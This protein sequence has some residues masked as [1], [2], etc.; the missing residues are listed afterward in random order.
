MREKSWGLADHPCPLDRAALD[1]M[2]GQCVCMFDV[3][4]EIFGVD[5]A[6]RA[7]IEADG[8]ALS[9]VQCGDRAAHPIARALTGLPQRGR[10]RRL[11]HPA[12]TGAD[13]GLAFEGYPGERAHAVSCPS[14]SPSDSDNVVMSDR[15]NSVVKR[16]GSLTCGKGNAS[17]SRA[18]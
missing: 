12:W 16:N 3:T 4:G 17:A 11:A 2:A 7:G 18:T 13:D 15:P 8:G 9:F 1:A 10:A 5:A 14:C 6:C